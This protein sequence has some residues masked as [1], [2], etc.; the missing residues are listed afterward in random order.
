M[1]TS[2][3]QILGKWVL[4]T[5]NLALVGQVLGTT[6]LHAADADR[7][8][9]V[10]IDHRMQKPWLPSVGLTEALGV[11]EDSVKSVMVRSPEKVEDVQ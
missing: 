9:P 7:V 1:R 3:T 6:H 4:L 2:A 11:S 10:A 8:T 5:L